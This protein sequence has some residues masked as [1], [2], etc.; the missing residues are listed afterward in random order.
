MQRRGGADAVTQIPFGGGAQAAGAAGSAASPAMS[1]F[2]MWVP[3][4]AVKPGPTAPAAASTPE[5]GGARR[6]RAHSVCSRR[7]SDTWAC[8]RQSRAWVHSAGLGDGYG[9][10]ARTEWTAAPSR[11]A[12]SGGNC[13][14]RSIHPPAVPSPKRSCGARQGRVEA[15]LEVAG[16]EQGQADARGGRRPP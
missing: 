13:W 3:W 4:M 6:C 2:D 14:T 5:R 1:A 11:W 8:S 7:C 10:T 9:G 12:R 15:A 16:V